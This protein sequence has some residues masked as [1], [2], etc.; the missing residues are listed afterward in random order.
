[1]E[2]EPAGRRCR[3]DVFSQGT[4]ARAAIFD[5]FNQVEQITQGSGEPVIRGGPTNLNR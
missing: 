2:D 3:V 5:R 4:E 1:M